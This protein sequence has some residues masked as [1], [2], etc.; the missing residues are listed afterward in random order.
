MTPLTN[1]KRRSSSS[2]KITAATTTG[3]CSN[4]KYGT[5]ICANIHATGGR[6]GQ[7]QFCGQQVYISRDSSL[8]LPGLHH[9]VS[10]CYL[11]TLRCQAPCF[12]PYITSSVPL[13]KVRHETLWCNSKALNPSFSFGMIMGLHMCRKFSTLLGE[14]VDKGNDDE[15]VS[16]T[17]LFL[18][19]DVGN[20]YNDDGSGSD[21]DSGSDSKKSRERDI[22][23]KEV[24]RVY[25]V[26]NELF[27][28]DRNM[29]AVLSQCNV[30]VSHMLVVDV[31]NRFRHA[32]KPA[33]RFFY[34]VG[35]QPGFSHDLQTYN[36]MM[37]ILGKTRQFESMVDMLEEMGKKGIV[38]METF[39]IATKAFA[40]GREMKKAVAIFELMRRYNF[41]ADINTLNALLDAL[42]RAKLAKEAQSLCERMKD[43]F[44]PDLKTYSVLLSGWCK[45]KNLV[46]AGK[47]WNEMVEQGF[48]PDVVAHNTML[49]G[50]FMSGRR[51]EAVKLFELMKVKGPLPNVRSYTILLRNLC[52]SNKMDAAVQYFDEMQAS[53]CKPDVAIYTC[54]IV[55]FGNAGKLV[56][57]YQLLQEMK[58]KGCP[59]D[60]RTYNALIKLMTNRNMPA[61]AARIYNK[62]IE[63]GLEPTIHTYNMIMKCFFLSKNYEM[64]L[65]IWNE[66]LRKG[67]C[68]DDNSYT[69]F[70]NGLIRTGRPEEACMYIEEMISKGMRAPQLDYNKFA[71]DFSKAGKPDILEEI[72]ERLKFSGKFE[73][74]NTFLR[75]SAQMKKRVKRKDS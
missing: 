58:K 36:T 64:G 38:T 24:D 57:V 33:S 73:D 37:N 17:G 12:L 55:G 52:K 9:L 72:A 61:D 4:R 7:G 25:K 39:V 46:E 21:S 50:L 26:V 8:S 23:V 43:R 16:D 65:A 14:E 67:C 45:V 34:W 1:L 62:M 31:L 20:D 28:S 75:L 11:Y 74:S 18:D 35:Q 5:F 15:V 30:Q 63:N 10:H 6:R 19:H 70:I 60:G 22:H 42:G 2:S 47:I 32:W 69:V 66:M 48:K 59:P 3:L 29:E 27:A 13:P 53:G 54:L 51:S 41:E 71:A 49:E 68:P 44:P 56:D 40:A